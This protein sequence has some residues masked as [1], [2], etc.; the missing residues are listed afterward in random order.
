M[1]V[2]NAESIGENLR[3]NLHFALTL[4]TTGS[5]HE[6]TV[7]IRLLYSFKENGVEGDSCEIGNFRFP[8]LSFF[9]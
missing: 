6:L 5:V 7:G 1:Y 2:C 3:T 9:S 8:S 4:L